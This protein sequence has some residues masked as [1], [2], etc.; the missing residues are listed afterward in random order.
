MS[1]E[2]GDDVEQLRST[3]V[4]VARQVGDLVA[5]MRAAGPGRVETKTSATD[6]VTAADTAA[7]RLAR[8]LLSQWR[9]GEP[10]WG[11]E[12][13]GDG[14]PTGGLCWVVDPIDGTVNYLYGLPW[15]AVS[16]AV[17]R[18]G[19]SLAGAVAQPADGRLWSAARGQGAEC[20]GVALRVSSATQ[21][22]L[23][24]I[25]TGF[26]YRPERR[27][28]QAAMV[29]AMLPKVRDVRRAGSAALDLCAVGSGWLDGF[30]EHGLQRWD[31]AAGALIASE[32][33][34]VVRLPPPGSDLVLAATPE[35][36]D[37]LG[38]L[39]MRCGA[40]TV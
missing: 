5:R 15:Y 8:R 19:Q 23:S 14:A 22:E 28:R 26:S 9:P 35:I 38:D 11:E 36:A 13:G 27:A 30:I 10:V 37:A 40:D 20:D 31:W 24:L 33:G 34:A 32:A 2:R 29:A 7:E 21:L 4:A 17:Q 12:E 39:V 18:D 6:V 25:G 3:A 1:N 16:V